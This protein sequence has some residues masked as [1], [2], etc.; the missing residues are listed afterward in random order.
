MSLL[1]DLKTVICD[2]L[3]ES[4]GV[5]DLL[6]EGER[7]FDITPRYNAD[8][9]SAAAPYIYVGAVGGQMEQQHGTSLQFNARVRLYCVTDDGDRDA[10]HEL[11]EAVMIALQDK[12]LD[13]ASGHSMEGIFVENVGDIVDPVTAQMVFVDLRA[14]V[15]KEN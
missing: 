6:G 13:M 5:T 7:I 3:R 14:I 10:A 15:A 2:H 8:Q 9:M 11:A 12:V 4:N 1:G